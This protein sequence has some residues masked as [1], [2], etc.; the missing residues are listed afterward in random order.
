MLLPPGAQRRATLPP[1]TQPPIPPRRRRLRLPH[2]DYAST[3]V[4]FVTICTTGKRHL[5]GTVMGGVL[6][7]TPLGSLVEACWLSIAD[8]APS[9]TVDSFVVMPNHLHGVLAVDG[10]PRTPHLGTVIRGF[11]AAATRDARQEGLA[12]A[13]APL[14]QRGYWEHVVRS[15][16]DLDRIREYV[17]TNPARWDLDREN[18]SRTG[19]DDFDAWLEAQPASRRP[20]PG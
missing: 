11:K 9:V 4:Y 7:P 17:D 8:H 10:G 3:A 15:P 5:L 2:W 1:V 14:W 16:S 18:P 20:S 19:R 13:S 12:P 6:V